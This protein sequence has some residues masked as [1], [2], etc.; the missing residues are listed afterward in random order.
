MPKSPELNKQLE[1]H[2]VPIYLAP[3]QFQLNLS[4]KLHY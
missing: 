2:K 4:D 1:G 3:K